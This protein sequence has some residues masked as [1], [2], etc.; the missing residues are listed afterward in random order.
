V[1]PGS[2]RGQRSKARWDTPEGGAAI[3]KGR[4]GTEIEIR[5]D[6]EMKVRGDTLYGTKTLKDG[7][8]AY[9]A[10]NW[11]EMET[12][13]PRSGKASRECPCHSGGNRRCA[14]SVRRSSPDAS[15]PGGDATGHAVR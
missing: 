7:E 4:D 1:W 8:I 13:G 5:T 12:R 11:G 14:D 6:L 15:D 9:C 2:S 10:L 3:A